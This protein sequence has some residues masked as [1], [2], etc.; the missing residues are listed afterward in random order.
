M[1][2]V[3]FMFYRTDSLEP[4]AFL[5]GGKG[6]S[7]FEDTAVFGQS[8]W[9]PHKREESLGL[10]LSYCQWL[11]KYSYGYTNK[12]KLSMLMR[13][14]MMLMQSLCD[15]S[16]PMLQVWNSSLSYTVQ[17]NHLVHNNMWYYY[18][19]LIGYTAHAKMM[20]TNSYRFLVIILMPLLLQSGNSKYMF[21]C[22]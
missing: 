21:M 16:K 6:M 4:Q 13:S 9:Y 22:M 15:L 3:A 14:L 17:F 10:R 1:S 11:I 2:Y 19:Y 7:G 18:N 12:K 8:I 5:C 20:E